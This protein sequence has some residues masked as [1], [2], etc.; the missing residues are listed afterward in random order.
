MEPTQETMAEHQGTV[1]PTASSMVQA[2]EALLM[3][4]TELAYW[5]I[6]AVVMG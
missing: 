5:D 2:V 6:A 4:R 1:M 3:W